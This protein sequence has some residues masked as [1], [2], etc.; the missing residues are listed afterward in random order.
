MA[1][2]VSYTQCLF[3]GAIAWLAL[4]GLAGLRVRRR[5]GEGRGY[6]QT[7]VRRMPSGL[8]GAEAR[9]S[10]PGFATIAHKQLPPKQLK[11]FLIDPHPKMPDLNLTR[12]EIEDIIAY[13]RSLGP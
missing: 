5:G 12:S 10:I 7:V 3:R 4:D 2:T 6:R 13:I 9:Q 8:A 11:T 1:G